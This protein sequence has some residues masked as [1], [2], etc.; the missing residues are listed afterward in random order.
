MSFCSNCGTELATSDQFCRNCG[1][2]VGAREAPRV[3]SMPAISLNL[4]LEPATIAPLLAAAAAVLCGYLLSLLLYKVAV[5]SVVSASGLTGAEGEILR[6]VLSKLSGK[7]AGI[8]FYMWHQVRLIGLGDLY[9]GFLGISGAVSGS[10]AG[11]ISFGVFVPL[12]SIMAMAYG[13]A[14]WSPVSSGREIVRRSL[15]FGAIY[16]VIMLLLRPTFTINSGD[17][18]IPG[19]DFLG[20]AST[21]F[22]LGPGFLSTLVHAFA[23]AALFGAV[24][25]WLAAQTGNW[26]SSVVGCVRNDEELVPS[27]AHSAIVAFLSAQVLLCLIVAVV[28]LALIEKAGYNAGWDETSRSAARLGVVN[29]TPAA[30]G[31]AYYLLV[32]A[33]LRV[34]ASAVTP[35][36]NSEGLSASAWLFA[37]ASANGQT[38][39]LPW[40][41]YLAVLVPIA[42]LIIGG[43]RAASRSSCSEGENSLSL[44]FAAVH[45]SLLVL[46]LPAYR[47]VADFSASGGAGD[48]QGNVLSASARGGPT[49]FGSLFAGLIVAFLASR[50]GAW[51]YS[52]AWGSRLT[53]TGS[54][55]PECGTS[56]DP[57]AEYCG[58]CGSKLQLDRSAT[59][60]GS[61]SRCANGRNLDDD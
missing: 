45:A 33:P 17:L 12:I 28:G 40:Y 52:H 2:D 32:G 57:D 59:T 6:T 55:C 39:A 31:M 3:P 15:Y 19:M 14:K 24:G 11:P 25:T 26:R 37:G 27:W 34:A 35:A 4:K 58:Q 9:L 30:A 38:T 50:A 29:Y 46:I 47:F 54:F 20:G 41:V 8:N 18:Q 13:G 53:R 22:K 42:T 49:L 56:S 60:E 16:S 48:F 10:L 51:L 61:P 7:V 5:A 44:K 43:W 36:G 1:H 23:F 21:S